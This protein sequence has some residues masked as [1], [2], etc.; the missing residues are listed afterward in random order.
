MGIHETHPD[1]LARLM[2]AR[3]HL[4]SVIRM[5]QEGQECLAVAQQMQ[6]VSKA[7]STAKNGY[8]HDHIDHCFDEAL[9]AKGKDS[10]ASLAELKEITKYL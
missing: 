8:V 10:R 1:T 6:A 7:I 4:D 2:R 3:G 9:L 5:I